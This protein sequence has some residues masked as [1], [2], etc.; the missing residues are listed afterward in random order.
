MV[1]DA[2]H[3]LSLLTAPELLPLVAPLT[4]GYGFG[5]IYYLRYLRARVLF[6]IFPHIWHADM[7]PPAIIAYI[8]GQ[9]SLA[10]RDFRFTDTLEALFLDILPRQAFVRLP[11]YRR[12][13][14][15]LTIV[16]NN[17]SER[18]SARD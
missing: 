7:M 9:V 1:Y 17:S 5:G 2:R 11:R 6:A 18:E 13:G 14:M 8:G 3:L 15:R 4:G 10:A 16:L 12:A